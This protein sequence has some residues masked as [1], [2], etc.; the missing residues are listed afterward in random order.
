MPFFISGGN[1][2]MVRY[3]QTLKKMQQLYVCRHFKEGVPSNF[4]ADVASVTLLGLSSDT[5]Q[6]KF[7]YQIGRNL[8][9]KI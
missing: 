7:I 6:F 9:C 1:T 8:A 5:I 3:F 4:K 2:N